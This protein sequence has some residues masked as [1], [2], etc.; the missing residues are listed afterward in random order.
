M[1]V[2]PT[3]AE[4]R[5]GGRPRS[6]LRVSIH[7]SDLGEGR[8]NLPDAQSNLGAVRAGLG[9]RQWHPGVAQPVSEWPVVHVPQT[10]RCKTKVQWPAR[11]RGENIYP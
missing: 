9:V 11:A 1:Q 5:I 8:R 3:S 4:W 6:P 7:Q 2:D 10:G